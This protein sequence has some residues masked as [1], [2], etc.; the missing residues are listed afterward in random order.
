MIVN[1]RS[2]CIGLVI[3]IVL[4]GCASTLPVEIRKAPAINPDV[5]DVKNNFE[6]FRNSEI[7]WGGVITSVENLS[8]QT[9]IEIVSR[10][11][12]GSGRP[13]QNDSSPGRFIANIEGYLDPVVYASGREMTVNGIVVETTQKSIGKF[14][15]DF[16]VVTVNQHHLSLL[17]Q[18]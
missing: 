16:P 10:G 3:G 8:N 17:L 11:L 9:L 12:Y 2:F 4:S 13:R 7:R 18:R 15:Y 5:A 6:R 1:F 14:E